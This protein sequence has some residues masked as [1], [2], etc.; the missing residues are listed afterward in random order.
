[1]GV[2]LLVPG[3]PA[4]MP[5]GSH[6]V[7]VPRLA[8]GRWGQNSGLTS[9]LNVLGEVQSSSCEQRTARVSW[10]EVTQPGVLHVPLEFRLPSH[11]WTWGVDHLGVSLVAQTLKDLPA[12]QETWV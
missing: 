12:M 8:E 2:A 7:K 3:E 9:F 5:S 11:V 10:E 4:Q 1:M 6:W